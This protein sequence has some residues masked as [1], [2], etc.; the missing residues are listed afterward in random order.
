VIASLTGDGVALAL[1]SAALATHC[2]LAHGNDAQRY[3]RELTR[4]LAGQMR[5]ASLI[6]AV[7]RM[8]AAQ[9]LVVQA[10]RAFPAAM[11]LAARATRSTL[12]MAD[13][14]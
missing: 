1:A 11:R 12:T 9:S 3:H 14:G 5:L 4:L 13:A 2:W 7:C 8:P 10:C 6:H